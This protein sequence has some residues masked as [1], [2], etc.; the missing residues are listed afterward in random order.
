MLFL[1]LSLLILLSFEWY[2]LLICPIIS[3]LET[4]N[5]ET[6]YEIPPI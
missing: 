2:L 5:L 3:Y 1:I 4:N 6:I